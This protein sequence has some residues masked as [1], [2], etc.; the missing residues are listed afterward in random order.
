VPVLNEDG[1]LAFRQRR[2]ANGHPVFYIISES[3]ENGLKT[4]VLGGAVMDQVFEVKAYQ[5]QQVIGYVPRT[6]TRTTYDDKDR[7]TVRKSFTSNQWAT[8]VYAETSYTY[9][10]EGDV[11]LEKTVEFSPEGP[12]KTSLG[13]QGS[14][15][16]VRGAFFGDQY[17]SLYRE[18]KYER[19][20]AEGITK[21]TTY[22]GVPFIST[23][24]GQETMSRYRDAGNQLDQSR[25]A[26]LLGIAKKLV[27]AG[28]GVRIST[29]REYGVQKR[30]NEVQRSIDANKKETSSSG[31]KDSAPSLESTAETVWTV[32]SATSQTSIE[33]SPPYV[34][35][36]QIIASGNN[37][38]TVIK[39][40]AAQKAMHFARTENRLLLG[41][42]NG[43]GIQVLPEMLPAE[44]MGLV[45]IRL[46]GCTAAFRVNG[47][48]YNIDPQGVT[49]T[50]DCLFWGAIDGTVAD[51]WFPLPPG[52]TTLPAPVAITTNASPKPANA[53]AI[54]NG[55]S[56]A[57][58]N[59]S[60][61]F[62]SL[63][64]AQAPVFP[65]TVTPGVLIK[66]YHETVTIAAGS[67]SGA[68]ATAL[69]W[70]RQPAMEVLAGSGSGV[71]T[72][73][74]KSTA[75][76]AGSGSGAIATFSAASGGDSGGAGALL[77]FTGGTSMAWGSNLAYGFTFTLSADKT[78]K[79]VGFYDENLNGLTGSY[80][81]LLLEDSLDLEDNLVVLPFDANGSVLVMN[82][83]SGTTAN[84]SGSW[85]RVDL[86]TA[87]QVL[88]AGYTY[89]LFCEPD[90]PANVDNLIKNASGITT[91]AN[92]T[93]GQ[94][95][96]WA[97]GYT[98]SSTSGDG[99]AYFG[100]MIFFE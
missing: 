64:T 84:P 14:Y 43:N 78:I 72:N 66:P 86:T 24:D 12:L 85:R 77:A 18:V 81:F 26:S 59:L 80:S 32:G 13:Y 40:D 6:I 10:S 3:I 11:I 36:D 19:N 16:A 79:G 76:I 99:T 97:T 4:T 2:D 22:T 55:F 30:P 98:P 89:T 1:S 83:P 34:S 70:I 21:T 37:Q 39:S 73:R 65:R 28:S 29:A 7:V 53:I 44:P 71:V 35:D 60:N 96:S 9:N 87:G 94:N 69:P 38:Y 20:K 47:T 57:S 93:F 49:A 74:L 88:T 91:L 31:K 48:T 75:A 52:A 82:V 15:I 92:A 33:L 46:N 17:Q 45:F 50:T 5:L 41:H 51:A 63:P 56:F 67:G 68:M 25:L 27:S 23:V 95:Y 8:D 61:L 100:P 62:T 42:R 58:P 90:N 54:P